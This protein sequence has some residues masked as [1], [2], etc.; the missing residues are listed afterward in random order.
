M[1]AIII[2]S[3]SLIISIAALLLAI[4]NRR[5]K[6]IITREEVVH[7]PIQHPFT[8]DEENGL[9]H[10]NGGLEVDGSFSCYH[11]KKK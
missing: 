9:F 5:V 4:R 3:V 1:A 6:E 7:A 11:S 2:A 10:L 8:Y